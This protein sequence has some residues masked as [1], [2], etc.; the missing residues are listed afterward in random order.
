MAKLHRRQIS[1]TPILLSKLCERAR[2][3]ELLLRSRRCARTSQRDVTRESN[4]I[5]IIRNKNIAIYTRVY[6]TPV[7]ALVSFVVGMA[8]RKINDGV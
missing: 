4:E 7:V 1:Y 6:L 5:Y 3:W 8:T 2:C